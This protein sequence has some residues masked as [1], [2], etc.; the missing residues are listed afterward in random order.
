VRRRARMV[1][2]KYRRAGIIERHRGRVTTIAEK[3]CKS[4]SRGL[5]IWRAL[6]ESPPLNSQLVL[7]GFRLVAPSDSDG[8]VTAREYSGEESPRAVQFSDL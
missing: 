1:G 4:A 3:F 7:F 2:S 8:A 5:I 6:I